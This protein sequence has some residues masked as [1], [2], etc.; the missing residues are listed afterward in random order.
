[1]GSSPSL[2]DMHPMFPT[3]PVA[4]ALSGREFMALGKLAMEEL[5]LLGKEQVNVPL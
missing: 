3:V 5:H 2:L 4:C 1:M